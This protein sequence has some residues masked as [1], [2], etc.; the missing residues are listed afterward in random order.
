[1]TERLMTQLED[2]YGNDACRL[3][4]GLMPLKPFDPKKTY[5]CF[6]AVD[7][8]KVNEGIQFLRDEVRLLGYIP[9]QFL[10]RV[11]YIE[12]HLCDSYVSVAWSYIP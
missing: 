7:P 1:M 11:R 2:E 8:N 3:L 12:K 6:I 9:E 10:G 4:M 5:G